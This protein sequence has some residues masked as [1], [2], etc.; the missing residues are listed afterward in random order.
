[1]SVRQIGPHGTV[2]RDTPP[3]RRQV[4]SSPNPGRRESD[5]VSPAVARFIAARQRGEGVGHAKVRRLS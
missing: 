1:M 2:F 5:R 4:A 3:D